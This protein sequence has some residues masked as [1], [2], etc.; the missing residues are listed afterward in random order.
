MKSNTRFSINQ[1]ETSYNNSFRDDLK[2]LKSDLDIEYDSLTQFENR[3]QF[4]CNLDLH[5]NVKDNVIGKIVFV[6]T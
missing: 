1:N 6:N 2:E 4:K 3:Y 5:L